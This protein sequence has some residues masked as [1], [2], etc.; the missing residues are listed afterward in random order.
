GG[1]SYLGNVVIGQIHGPS[2]EVVRLHFV[3]LPTE[4]TGR[5]F[6][7]MEDLSGHGVHSPDLVSNANGDGIQLGER[8]TYEIR[9]Y[10]TQLTI[11]IGRANRP[12]VKY[13]TT[14]TSGYAGK[15]LYFKAGQYNQ[16][17]TGDPA[18]YVQAT[19]F[20]LTHTHP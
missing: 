16:D 15:N 1:T 14:I 10:G 19:F 2:T 13:V 9:L 5:I 7:A 8:F 20:K 4:S 6:A 11:Y 18:D 17:N 3:K 12:T